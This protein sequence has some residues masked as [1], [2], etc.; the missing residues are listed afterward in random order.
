MIGYYLS[1][2]AY[3]AEAPHIFL[4]NRGNHEKIV[5][6]YSVFS[7]LIWVTA[8]EFHHQVNLL[9]YWENYLLFLKHGHFNFKVQSSVIKWTEYHFSKDELSTDNRL[10]IFSISNEVSSTDVRCIAMANKCFSV[11]YKHLSSVRF[12]YVSD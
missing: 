3:L 10:K 9:G 8:A 2:V 7:T 5:M 12:G 1:S 4:G 6:V 11:T